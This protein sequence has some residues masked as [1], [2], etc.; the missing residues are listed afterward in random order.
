MMGSAVHVFLWKM[1]IMQPV[2]PNRVQLPGHTIISFYRN[3]LL[4]I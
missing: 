1:F 2:S 4:Y 3:G